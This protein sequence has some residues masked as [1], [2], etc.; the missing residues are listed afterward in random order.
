MALTNLR[1]SIFYLQQALRNDCD[2]KRL[3]QALDLLVEVELNKNNN[4]T[5]ELQAETRGTK[6]GKA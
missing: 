1:K 2:D 4:E 6:E 3:Y 5:K